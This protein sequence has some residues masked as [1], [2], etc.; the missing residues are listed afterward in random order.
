MGKAHRLHSTQSQTIYSQPLELVF[1]DLWGPAPSTSSGFNYYITFIDAYSRYTW[2]YL[3]KSKSEALT[4]FKQFKNMAELQLGYPLKAL[5]SDWRGEFRPFTKYLTELGITHRLICP[6]T[7]H[8]N[9]VVE[10]KHRHVVDMG[11]TLLSQSSLP[12]TYWDHAFLTAVHLINR[13]PTA[14]EFQNTLYCA[15][16]KSS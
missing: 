9:G 8:Q 7:H 15:V 10:R 6:H 4:I 12:L 1:S 13:L 16:S 11:L 14:S 5:Q 3:I 2:I